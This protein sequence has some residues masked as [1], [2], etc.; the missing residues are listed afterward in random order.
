MCAHVSHGIYPSLLRPVLFRLDPERAH[1]LAVGALAAA[2]PVIGRLARPPDGGGR[3]EQ[4]LLGLRFPNPVGLAAGFD[5]RA[6]AVP[7]WP[8]L[9]FGFAEVGTVTAH[10]QPGNPR[11]RIHRLPADRALINRLGFNNAGARGHGRDARLAGGA[12]ACS[13]APR[14]A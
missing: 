6:R 7:A 8:A 4:Q 5:K 2:S 14:W 11:P 3:L 1:E 10:G 9:G 13:A 12:G